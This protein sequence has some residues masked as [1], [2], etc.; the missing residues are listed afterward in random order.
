MCAAIANAE[1]AEVDWFSEDLKHLL[2]L[3]SKKMPFH[4]RGWE[5]KI[6]KSRDTQNNRQAW[7][8]STKG[9]RAKANRV[10]SRENTG[11]SK[12]S[13]QTIQQMTLYMDI[14]SWST[15]KSD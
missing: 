14:T 8:W 12:H 4:H 1:G 11:H 7:P 13:F 3:I 10:L 2:E 5:C 15:L 6:R 9:N